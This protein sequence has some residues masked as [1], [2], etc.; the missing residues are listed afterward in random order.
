M[1]GFTRNSCEHQR[2][3]SHVRLRPWD[4]HGGHAPAGQA[5]GDNNNTKMGPSVFCMPLE[6]V[7]SLGKFNS[8]RVS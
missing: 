1:G 5:G 8:S 4:L 3:F 7:Q 6:N 2:S